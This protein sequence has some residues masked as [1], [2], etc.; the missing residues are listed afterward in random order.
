MLSFMLPKQSIISNMM[1]MWSDLWNITEVMFLLFFR[2]WATG[3]LML[4]WS[5][6]AWLT[7]WGESIYILTF[8]LPDITFKSIMF[9][10]KSQVQHTISENSITSSSWPR[11]KQARFYLPYKEMNLKNVKLSSQHFHLDPVWCFSV[12]E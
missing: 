3:L 5:A 12:C 11:R 4:L 6:L 10:D 8:L 2:S 9:D 1:N 7:W